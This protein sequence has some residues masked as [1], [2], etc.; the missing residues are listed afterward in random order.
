VS[1]IL[2][3]TLPKEVIDLFTEEITTVVVSTVT[4]DGKPHA[5]PVGLI[6]AKDNKTIRM[7]LM[8]G[9]QSTENI[10]QNGYALITIMDAPDIAIGIK[11]FAQVIKEPM[12][13]SSAM[14][15][16]EFKVEQVKSDTTPTVTIEQGIRIK[17]RSEKS[18]IFLRTMFDE[19]IN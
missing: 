7:G 1:K 16:V 4:K 11:G 17:P 6:Q 13:G 18:A 10:K 2:G 19:L 9:H 14:S 5:L 8:K 3:D 12:N 15:L